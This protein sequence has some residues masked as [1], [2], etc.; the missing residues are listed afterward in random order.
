LSREKGIIDLLDAW[1]RISTPALL[2]V[3]G[4]DMPGHPWDEGPRA[5]ALVAEPALAGRV[6]LFGASHDPAP[7]YRAA[8]FAVVPSHWES[9]GISAAE[10]MSTGLAVVASAVGGLLD[11]VVDGEN[12]WFVAPKDPAGL[13]A[14]I[15]SVARDAALR[16]R[17]G[18]AARERMQRFDEGLVLER[19]GALIDRLQSGGS[20][21]ER[22]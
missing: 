16:R 12:G 9:F 1:Q 2:V 6:V 17:L 10:A 11:Y 5:R 21:A 3:V 13:A 22:G 4:P 19:F 15:D 18:A 20:F 7:L 14:A 8:D